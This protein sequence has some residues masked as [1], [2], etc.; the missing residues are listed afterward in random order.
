MR[1]ISGEES[2]CF[3]PERE[4]KE[5]HLDRKRRFPRQILIVL[6]S[7]SG[8]TGPLPAALAALL[9]LTIVSTTIDTRD[10]PRREEEFFL[11]RA[12]VL[13]IFTALISIPATGAASFNFQIIRATREGSTAIGPTFTFVSTPTLAETVSY[14]FQYFDTGLEEANYTYSVVLAAGSTL[15]AAGAGS[16][17]TNA[18]LTGIA[19]ED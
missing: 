11:D 8:G 15:N 17:I 14:V 19:V 13:L 16:T 2:G 3:G 5:R 18:R 12:N 4:N 9:P 7:S 10:R 1:Y 6:N